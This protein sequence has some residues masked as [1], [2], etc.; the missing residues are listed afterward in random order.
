LESCFTES[1][2]R[3][4]HGGEYDDRGL[5]GFEQ[6]GGDQLQDRTASQDKRSKD[7]DREILYRQK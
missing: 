7:H 5:L 4:S 1:W 2:T 3:G 6:I